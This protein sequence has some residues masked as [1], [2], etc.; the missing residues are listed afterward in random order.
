MRRKLTLNRE[1]LKDLTP[2][3]ELT[4]AIGGAS[5]RTVAGCKLVDKIGATVPGITGT[6]NV[7]GATSGLETLFTVACP[8]QQDPCHTDRCC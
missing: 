4:R 7:E 1:T 2:S 8:P 6:C 3:D 5:V